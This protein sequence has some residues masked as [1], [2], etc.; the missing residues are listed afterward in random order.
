MQLTQTE[1]E[2][3]SSKFWDVIR[4]WSEQ[5]LKEYEKWC[6]ENG[7]AVHHNI[8]QLL[9]T[10]TP[11][12]LTRGTDVSLRQFR[13]ELRKWRI[14]Q[15]GSISKKRAAEKA[16]KAKQKRWGVWI[17]QG[18]PLKDVEA[19]IWHI[20]ANLVFR[21]RKSRYSSKPEY[22]S[23]LDEEEI[24]KVT[25]G[26]IPPGID[27][28]AEYRKIYHAKETIAGKRRQN[29][30]YVFVQHKPKDKYMSAAHNAAREAFVKA[31]FRHKLNLAY[32][33]KIVLAKGPEN[34]F[35]VPAM[36]MHDDPPN[37]YRRRGS[38]DTNVNI[39]IRLDWYRRIYL[40]GLANAFGPRTFVLDVH[41]TADGQRT[42]VTLF[43]QPSEHRYKTETVT[44]YLGRDTNGNP[45][46]MEE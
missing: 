36:S 37:T 32:D 26:F 17:E 5:T 13:R 31:G 2:K 7:L 44:G 45:K 42:V 12:T 3:K 4:Q 34:F 20:R 8:K 21:K 16:E 1:W 39:N 10:E 11:T 24:R 27:F 38:R 28:E 22:Q 33:I 14:K 43:R 6:A 46:F 40:T 25:G 30:P 19:I 23:W 29:P 35:A 41:P 9:V 15:S 18:V